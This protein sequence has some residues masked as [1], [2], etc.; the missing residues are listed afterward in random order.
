MIHERVLEKGLALDELV[1]DQA[2]RRGTR[3]VRSASIAAHRRCSMEG[4]CTTLS[5]E[6]CDGGGVAARREGDVPGEAGK[7]SSSSRTKSYDGSMVVGKEC[8]RRL[9]QPTPGVAGVLCR[10]IVGNL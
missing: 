6:L 3:T 2:Q 10:T 9:T 4:C 5:S 1:E 8:G 7:Y